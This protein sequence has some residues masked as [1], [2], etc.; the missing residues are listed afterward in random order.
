MDFINLFNHLSN[1]REVLLCSITTFKGPDK[2]YKVKLQ[3]S[4][5][6]GDSFIFTYKGR[7]YYSYLEYHL[8]YKSTSATRWLCL[9]NVNN[10]YVHDHSQGF[11]I[12]P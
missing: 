11:Q 9:C 10:H 1:N 3:A 8:T 2:R 7:E 5:T 12:V 4:D 6:R